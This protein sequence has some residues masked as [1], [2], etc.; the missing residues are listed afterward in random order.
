MARW[1]LALK[2]RFMQYVSPEPNSGCWLWTG[3]IGDDGYGRF[4]IDGGPKRAHRVSFEMF[5]GPIPD[6]ID[7]CHTCDVRPCVC[8]D[9]LFSG[10]R[11][12]NNI[13]MARKERGRKSKSGLPFGV[14]RNGR[15]KGKPFLVRVQEDGKR[16]HLG[17][18]A[19]VDEAHAVAAAFRRDRWLAGLEK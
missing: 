14:S 2:E 13:D 9:H 4:E 8:P 17:A 3:Q 7:C 15:S 12:D 10:T 5:I 6:G 18:F 11:N 1:T 19:T 16:H